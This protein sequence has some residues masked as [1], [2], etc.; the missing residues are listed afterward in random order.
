MAETMIEAEKTI[1]DGDAKMRELAHLHPN[2]SLYP[3]ALIGPLGP[4]AVAALGKPDLLRGY[5]LALFCSVKCPGDLI[6][7]LY[8]LA[9]NL[10]QAGIAVISGFHS[11]MERECLDIL[12]RGAQP[13]IACPARSLEGMRIRAEH[14]QPLAEGRLLFLSPFEEKQRRP[15]AQMALCRNRFVAALADEVFVAYAEPNGKTEQFCREL[16][17]WGKPVYT[18]ESE[19]NARL[20]ELGAKAVAVAW[21]PKTGVDKRRYPT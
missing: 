9:R 7:K 18:F 17:A 16:P 4:P 14:K 19:A 20:V 21:L 11:P 6:L 15:T 12:L 10:R 8:D 13:V 1:K 2:D 3:R 5:K